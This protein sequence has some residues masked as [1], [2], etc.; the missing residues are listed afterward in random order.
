MAAVHATFESFFSN[1]FNVS[2]ACNIATFSSITVQ[3]EANTKWHKTMIHSKKSYSY[4]ALNLFIE[5]DETV[6]WSSISNPPKGQG[7]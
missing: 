4:L 6:Q 7:F 5:T 3:Y 1:D 2:I